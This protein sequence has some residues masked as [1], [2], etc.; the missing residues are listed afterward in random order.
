MESPYAFELLRGIKSI[1]GEIKEKE[2][3]ITSFIVFFSPHH[4]TE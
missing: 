4:E 3:Q 1:T 2:I